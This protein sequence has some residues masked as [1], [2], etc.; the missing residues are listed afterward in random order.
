VAINQKSPALPMGLHRPSRQWPTHSF[1]AADAHTTICHS[2]SGPMASRKDA[3]QTEEQ[4]I[5][6]W[7]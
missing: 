3:T 1:L 7:L 4:D 6:K 5:E 2:F